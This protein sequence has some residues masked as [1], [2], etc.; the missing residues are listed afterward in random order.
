GTR[1]ILLL[2]NYNVHKN[3]KPIKIYVKISLLFKKYNLK[4]ILKYCGDGPSS[5][6]PAKKSKTRKYDERYLQFGFTVAGTDA[7]PLPQ[8]V[9]C[10]DLLANDSVKPCKLKCHLETKHPTLKDKSLDFFRLKLSCLTQQKRTISKHTS[11]SNKCLEASYCVSQRIAR[12]HTITEVL[13]LPAAK[14]ICQVMFGENFTQRIGDIPFSNDTVS[15]HISD[16]ANDIKEQLLLDETTDVVGLAQLLTYVRYINVLLNIAIFLFC[17]SLPAHTTGESLFDILD[18]YIR[19]AGMSWGSCVGICTDGTRSMTGKVSGLV[20]RVLHLAPL[21]KWTHCMIHRESL[22]SKQMPESLESILKQAVQMVSFIKAWPLNARLFSLL[23]QEMGAEHEQ[24]LFHT[25]VRW[26]SRGRILHRLYKLHSEVKAFLVDVKF[27]LARYLDDP[28][29]LHLVDIFKR[30]NLLNR[31]MQGRD[32]NILLL[33][34]KVS[35]FIGK[36]DLWHDWLMNK[37]VDMFPIFTDCVQETG[38]NI[39]PLINIV[40]Q[41]VDGLKQ[42]FVPY[43]SEDFSSFAWVRDPFSCPG[44]DLSVD[45][46]EQLVELKSDTRLRHLYSSC[47]LPSFWLTVMTEYP[48]LSDAAVKLLLPFASAYLCEV[49]FSKLT[50]LKTKYRNRLQVEDDLRLALSN[51]EPRVVLLCKKKQVQVSH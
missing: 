29:W 31:S 14:D 23:C 46:E 48:Q 43:F 44:K 32:A 7:E 21:A 30:L 50:A 39:S 51:I 35:A 4:N 40:T 3:E 27:D 38:I 11:V 18:G 8:C 10:A 24:L 36:L 45:M 25:E 42:Q 28:L 34:E 17:R 22:A 41:H 20:T 2:F 16:M 33:S 19:D 37:N 26:L 49:G 6:P 47:S 13:I 1:C 12:F 15:R 5:A 9:I